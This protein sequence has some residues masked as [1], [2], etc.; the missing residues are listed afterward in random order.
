MNAIRQPSPEVLKCI[1]HEH[2][3]ACSAQRRVSYRLRPPSSK[4]VEDCSL[5]VMPHNALLTFL[6]AGAWACERGLC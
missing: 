1:D 5:P 3:T 4:Y 2:I 6:L